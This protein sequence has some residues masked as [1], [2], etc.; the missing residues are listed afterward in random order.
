MSPEKNDQVAALLETGL[1]SNGMQTTRSEDLVAAQQAVIGAYLSTFQLL[2]GLA[3]LLGMFGFGV[4]I[5]RNASERTGEYA[6]LRAAGYRT[7]TLQKL[8]LIESGLVLSVGVGIGLLA[9]VIAVIPNA[10][11]GGQV[12][13]GRL[14]IMLGGIVLVGVAVAYRAT[15]RIARLPVIASLRRE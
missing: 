11:L 5:L 7:A 1:Q 4:V 2:G 12:A 3:L 8:V 15:A 13:T 14:G 6:I 10:A 9:A